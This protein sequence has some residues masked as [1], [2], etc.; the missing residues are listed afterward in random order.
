MNKIRMQRLVVIVA[1]TLFSLYTIFFT[2]AKKE[3]PL[4]SRVRNLESQP[5]ELADRPT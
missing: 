4:E 5:A 2:K 3:S 1:L